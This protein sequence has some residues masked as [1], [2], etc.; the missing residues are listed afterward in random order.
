ME[1]KMLTLEAFEEAL[2]QGFDFTQLPDF[3]ETLHQ[4]IYA[5]FQSEAN[6][7]LWADLRNYVT[8]APPVEQAP[9]AP[10]NP[11]MGKT[12]VVTG[13]VEP[14]TRDGINAKIESLGARAGSSVSSKTDYLICGENAGSKLD[15]A[16]SLGVSVLSPAEFFRMIGE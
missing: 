2:L 14:Y 5:W 8:I 7:C 13:K 3:G 6:W 1:K 11:F 12:I 10:D 9:P 16:R 15:K 4:N